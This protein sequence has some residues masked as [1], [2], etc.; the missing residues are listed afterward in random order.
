MCDT[1]GCSTEGEAVLRMP[2]KTGGHIH[3][4]LKSHSHEH[5]SGDHPHDHNHDHP[6]SRKV[7][8][9]Q[10]VLQ[11]N[12]LLAER[13]RGFFEARNIFALNFLSSPGSGKTS[14]LEALI[15]ALQA[16]TPVA[17]IEGDQQTTNDADRIHAL[18]V[19]VIQI[20]TGSG[21]HLDAMMVNRA[22]RELPLP[23]G[24]LLCIENVGNLVCPA[25]FDLGEALKVVIISVTEGDDKPLKYPNMFH[26]SDVCIL[27]KTDL[28]PYVEFDALKCRQNAMQVNHHLQW[29][30][31]SA[32]TGAGMAPLQEW[33]E[34]KLKDH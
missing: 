21:C 32:K 12:N 26:E 1:C 11:Q 30:E 6:G 31:V 33:I 29:F 17:V 24:T 7:L 10:D 4:D 5:A 16:S 22:I 3:M 8:L 2:G 20:N 9:E 18:G 25:M 28:L 13:N 27:N 14:L 34:H 15:P 23:D 19:P